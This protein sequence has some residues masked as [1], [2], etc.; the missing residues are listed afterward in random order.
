MKSM[1]MMKKQAQAGFT[2]IELM[3]VVA[4][5]GILAAVAIPQ[6]SDYTV[7]TKMATTMSSVDS[8]K[9]GVALCAQ[10][11]GG[12]FANCNSGANGV[13][14]FTPTK[15]LKSVAVAA[16]VITGTFNTGVGKDIDNNTVIFTPTIAAGAS[17]VKWDVT[18]TATNTVAIAALQK[19]NAAAASQ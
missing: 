13:P 2:L 14:V 5:I 18:T 15:E 17:N 4:I 3:I 9:T 11:A 19:N 1:K 12:D 6:Y 8:I 7:K 10:E 16:G